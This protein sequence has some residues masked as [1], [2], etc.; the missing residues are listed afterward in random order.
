MTSSIYLLN[1][2]VD[3]PKDRLHP[4]KKKRPIAA[5]QL[6]V[7][8]AFFLAIAGILFS[9]YL[10]Y[11][12]NFFFFFAV[13][14]YFLLQLAYIFWLKNLIVLDV[15]SV[16]GGFILR[17]YAG[18]FAI[19]VHL[20]VWFLLCVVSLAL[21]LTVGKRR[22]ELAILTEQ[23]APR[24]RH[25][26]SFYSADLLDSYLTMFAN[27]A[28]LAYALF[29]FFTPP[30]L[31]SQRLP[32]LADLPL[33][34]AGINKWLM[35]TIPVVI[36][37]VMRYMNIIYQGNRAESPE[38]VLLSDKS[39]LATVFIWGIMVVGILYGVRP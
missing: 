4:F 35:L 3:L 9:L 2:I 20:N 27:S 18:A 24:H 31:I 5:G 36:Y 10:S 34:L 17:V 6:A 39:L 19:N 11:L 38:R 28:W 16:A 37:G 25:T 1:D 32:F 14:T 33:T 7:P 26:L 15:I 30:P 22:A 29:T 21:F 13:L 8:T 23:L 12:Q